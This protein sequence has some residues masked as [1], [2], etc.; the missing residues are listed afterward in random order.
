MTFLG[1]F[2]LTYKV[3]FINHFTHTAD[4][5]S[6]VW[7]V[8]SIHSATRPP[9]LSTT[10]FWQR[11]VNPVIIPWMRENFATGPMS[12]TTQD[13]YWNESVSW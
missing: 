5:E 4:I 13:F 10:E 11:N 2:G 3:N 8:S 1:G 6:H 9:Y 12:N 7:N